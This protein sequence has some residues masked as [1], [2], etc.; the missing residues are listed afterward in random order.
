MLRTRI[1]IVEDEAIIAEDLREVL[2][3]LGYDVVAYVSSGEQAIQKAVELKPDLILMDIMIQGD[4]DGIETAQFIKVRIDIPIIFV[5][6]NADE[7]TLKRAKVSEPFGYILKPFEERELNTNIE[8]ALYRH[9]TEKEIK[10]RERWL[11]TT[12]RSIGDAVIST[13]VNGKITFIN[14]TAELLTGWM[15]DDVIDRIFKDIFI[16]IDFDTKNEIADPIPLVLKEKTT[17]D[18]LKDVIVNSKSGIKIPVEVNTS[19]IQN[20]KGLV[21]GVVFILKDISERKKAEE[22]IRKYTEDLKELN[23][24]KDKFFSIIAHDLKNPFNAIINSSKLMKSEYDFFSKADHLKFLDII[25][26]SSDA[27]FRL[28]ENLLLWARMQSGKIQLDKNHFKLTDLFKECTDLL[29]NQATEK[30]ITISTK[31]NSSNIA[32]SDYFMIG[33]VVRNLLGNAIKYTN[34]GGRINIETSENENEIQIDIKDS[35]VGIH[36]DIAEKLFRIDVN[37]STTGTAGEKGTGL[38]LIICKD[39][40]AANGGRIW[41]ASKYREGSTFSFTLPKEEKEKSADISTEE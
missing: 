34:E 18:L 31:M 20:E 19:P 8:I 7:Q 27:A 9:K 16:F 24:S 22:A 26:K 32:Y 36:K 15:L 3:R 33:T 1:L 11:N 2:V 17:I 35:G 39:F 28:L 37:A 14:K 10:E 13:D 40:I 25:I 29:N 12:L 23:N 41:V 30:K 5:T 38:G 6:G 4:I 21:E